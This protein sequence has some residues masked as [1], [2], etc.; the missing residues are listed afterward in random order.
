MDFKQVIV[1]RRDVSLSSKDMIRIIAHSSV[2]GA[3]RTKERNAKD[4]QSWLTIGQKKITARV[5]NLETLI[6]L[7]QACERKSVLNVLIK[8][9]GDMQPAENPVTEPVTLVI[10]PDKEKKIHP[11]TGHLKLF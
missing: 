2:I 9:P 3:E 5:E 8:L 7:Q 11:L 4:F 1:L 6:H 10:G